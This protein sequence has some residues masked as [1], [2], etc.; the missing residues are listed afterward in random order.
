MEKHVLAKAAARAIAANII[1]WA[2]SASVAKTPPMAGGYTDFISIPVDD[3]NVKAIAGALFKPPGTGPFP[4]IVYMSGCGGLPAGAEQTQEK[5]VIDH[6]TAKGVAT[7]IVDPFSP[8]GETD[9]VCAKVTPETARAYFGRGG[10]DAVAAINFLK[11]M[12]DI[13]PKRIF[14]QGYSFG[15]ISSLVAVDSTNP[16]SKEPK[17][18][19]VIAFYP[20]CW[21]KVDPTVSTLVMIGE[22]DDWTPAALCESVKDKA[23]FEVVV[24][25]GA[26]HAFTMPFDKPFDYL[27]HHIVYDEQAAKDSEPEQGI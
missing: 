9:G 5:S 6:M 23:N 17:V 24:Y 7:L 12:P 10:K 27:G 4:A 18:A 19:G 13:D 14:L 1:V 16:A 21:D 26:T 20:Y 8:R 25:P 3:P 22:K 15:A 11:A 2:P